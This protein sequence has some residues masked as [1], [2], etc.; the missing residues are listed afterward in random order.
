MGC[1]TAIMRLV[2]FLT[3]AII[4]V[5]AIVL[6]AVGSMCVYKLDELRTIFNENATYLGF[7]SLAIGMLLLVLGITGVCGACVQGTKSCLVM[8]LILLAL[9]IMAEVAGIGMLFYYSADDDLEKEISGTV[10]DAFKTYGGNGTSNEA[11]TDGIDMF[12]ETLECCGQHTYK[13]WDNSSVA[14]TWS[15]TLNYGAYL[16]DSCCKTVVDNCGRSLTLKTATDEEISKQFYTEGCEDKIHSYLDKWSGV[17]TG[18]LIAICVLQI[19][20]F[21]FG[22]CL[23]CVKKD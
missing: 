8:H 3:N 22:V 9:L 1:G 17:V 19:L 4:T 16:P 20:C 21:L 2:L 15:V 18:I 23:T 14:F 12:Q 6:I 10:G 11:I 13:D 5:F 7:G